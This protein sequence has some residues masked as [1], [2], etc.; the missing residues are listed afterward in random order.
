MPDDLA[1]CFDAHAILH[2]FIINEFTQAVKNEFGA[3]YFGI[4]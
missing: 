3:V 1:P 4:N 2:K